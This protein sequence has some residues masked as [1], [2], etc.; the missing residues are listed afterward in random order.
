MNPPLI[1]HKFPALHFDPPWRLLCPQPVTE[2]QASIDFEVDLLQQVGCGEQPPTLYLMSHPRCLVA[3]RRE[4]RMPG[5]DRARVE[6]AAAGWPLVVRASGGSCV[7]QGPGMLNLSL[8]FPRR[9][10][11]SLEDGY[12]FLCC[13][14]GDWLES[15]GLKTETGAVPGS[16]CDGRYNLQVAGQKLVGTAQRWAGGARDKAAILLH[17]CLLVDFE[18]EEATAHLNQLYRL[19]NN[20]QRFAVK[21]SIDLRRLLDPQKEQPD[22]FAQMEQDLIAALHQ[23]FDLPA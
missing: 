8:V 23:W 15:Y 22:F 13:L 7:P 18:L 3:T 10:D 19:C 11:W 12:R 9:K 14:L 21:A 20:P 4:A 6:L 5:F 2:P 16:F 1:R 17:A